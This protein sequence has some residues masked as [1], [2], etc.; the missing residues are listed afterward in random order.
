[1]VKMG[2]KMS[3]L[4]VILFTYILLLFS[5]GVYADSKNY[6]AYTEN[7]YCEIGLYSCYYITDDRSNP[8]D[9]NGD[10]VYCFNLKK[11]APRYG[12]YSDNLIEY[13]KVSGSDAVYS[14]YV[15]SK[16]TA[17]LEKD[18][19]NIIYKGYP[20]DATG[21]QEKYNLS[22]VL[23]RHL[24]QE[25]VWSKTD[26]VTVSTN[27]TNDANL[28]K[29]INDAYQELIKEENTIL[30]R[31]S[32]LEK[33]VT[34][35]FYISSNNEFQNLLGVSF[36][37]P[38]QISDLDDEKSEDSTS[39][40]SSDDDSNLEDGELDDSDSVDDDSSDDSDLD[41]SVDENDENDENDIVSEETSVRKDIPQT[42]DANLIYVYVM[43]MV[44]A[45]FGI[46]IKLK[47]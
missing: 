28:N 42:D 39:D 36:K 16:N 11:L 9:L 10:V 17:E 8:D 35:E 5:A 26:D 32:N 19:L 34:L 25:A 37:S 45:G 13:S 1:M 15:A 4:G 21:I 40:D 47:K 30:A 24:T 27:W 46:V 6:W 14:K 12:M 22:D 7:E 44:L 2:I 31:D 43:L 33:D 23:F 18:V 29:R 41:E 3:L 38:A 20:Y